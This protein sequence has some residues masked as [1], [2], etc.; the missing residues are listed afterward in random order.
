MHGFIETIRL[1]EGNSVT[2]ILYL[3]HGHAHIH[4]VS[5]R[6]IYLLACLPTAEKAITGERRKPQANGIKTR[7]IY[8]KTEKSILI[9]KVTQVDMNRLTVSGMDGKLI[10]TLK[11][12]VRKR[13][14]KCLLVK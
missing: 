11:S 3:T 1:S 14:L 10:L 7:K 4:N 5:I 2:I 8:T 12:S 6:V 9:K 13:E